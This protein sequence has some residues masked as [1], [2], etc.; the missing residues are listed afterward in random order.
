MVSM[1]FEQELTRYTSILA[2]IARAI[3][4]LEATDATAADVYI[5]WLGI[6]ST[7]RDLFGRPEDET[8]IPHELAKKITAIVNKRYKE[9]IDNAPRD[10]YFTAFF[11]HPS[12]SCPS[13][14]HPRLK[15]ATSKLILMHFPFAEY[16]RANVLAKPT[17]V[18]NAIYVP[19][20]RT[21]SKSSNGAPQD[22]SLSAPIPRAYTRVKTFLK[23]LLHGI[24]TSNSHPLV[25]T[26]GEAGLADE[27]RYQLLAY[28]WGEY[29][30]NTPLPADTSS[31]RPVLQWWLHLEHH[32]HARVLAVSPGFFSGAF[33][34][35]P[36][37]RC[38][39]SSST[40]L[41][42]TQWRRN[43]QFRPSH[44]STQ[45]CGA[46]SR[47]KLSLT[48]FKFANGTYTRFA[49]LCT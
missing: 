19:P 38:S 22:D 20:P 39:Q 14:S 45:N 1:K 6:A 23:E 4:S 25:S 12:T 2:P 8:G 7:L 36:R 26:L 30:F 41:L 43:A 31:G 16:A 18:S 40:P 3:K 21:Q 15:C 17:S 29:P 27:L 33:P 49:L 48:W 10:V 46:I 13:A 44:G 34:S 28:A 11:L 9:I 5:F 42:S 47:Y 35:N 24:I 37:Y 32:V